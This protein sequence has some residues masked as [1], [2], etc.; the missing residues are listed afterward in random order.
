MTPSEVR[1]FESQFKRSHGCWIWDG[2][3]PPTGTPQLSINGKRTSARRASYE[4]WIEPLDGGVRL[5]VLCDDELCVNPYHLKAE[6]FELTGDAGQSFPKHQ[7]HCR[8]LHPFNLANTV[9]S[10]NNTRLCR[11]C[12]AGSQR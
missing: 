7:T 8:N 4:H 9:W 5:T 11:I 10:G 6:G 3:V 12:G 2:N 1:R